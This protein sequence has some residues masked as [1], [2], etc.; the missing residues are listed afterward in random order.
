MTRYVD[1]VRTYDRI[2]P[3]GFYIVPLIYAPEQWIAC[4]AKLA[5]PRRAL[6]FGVSIDS[7]WRKDP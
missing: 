7:W 3:S 5:H 4:S 1:A 2:L 6:L